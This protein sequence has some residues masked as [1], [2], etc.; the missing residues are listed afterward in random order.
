VDIAPG[1]ASL[2]RL[3]VKHK[4]WGMPLAV[5][6][7]IV[8]KGGSVLKKEMKDVA[9]FATG[10]LSLNEEIQKEGLTAADIDKIYLLIT[11]TDPQTLA[12][13]E[14]QIR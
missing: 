7:L 1:T 13:Y 5:Q 3:G 12:E 14:I 9:A 6:I 8:S 4:E 2:P 10:W 11:N